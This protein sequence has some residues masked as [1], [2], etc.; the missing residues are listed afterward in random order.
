METVCFAGMQELTFRGRLVINP[1]VYHGTGA[2]RPGSD[3]YSVTQ[4]VVNIWKKHRRLVLEAKAQVY[5]KWELT[6]QLERADLM[7]VV[8][9]GGLTEEMKQMIKRAEELNIDID[10]FDEGFIK[11]EVQEAVLRG[12]I[13][14]QRTERA[15]T[16]GRER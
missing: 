11:R 15:K 14:I 9:N 1:L 13:M 7:A 2:Y 8:R 10:Y 12:N 5:K 16:H 4:Q 3:P 6:E